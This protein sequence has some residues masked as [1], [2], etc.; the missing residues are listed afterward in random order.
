M[1]RSSGEWGG[2]ERRSLGNGDGRAEARQG[3]ISLL[4]T[5]LC[6]VV[7]SMRSQKD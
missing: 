4:E 1:S 6:C 3:V 2:G 7:V 5:L